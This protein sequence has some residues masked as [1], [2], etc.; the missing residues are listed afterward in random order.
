[1][2][3][4]FNSA[5]FACDECRH[6]FTSV[7][8]ARTHGF[9]SCCA[10]SLP[11]NQSVASSF[12]VVNTPASHFPFLNLSN[13]NNVVVETGAYFAVLFNVVL[14]LLNLSVN[15]QR[16]RRRR[17]GRMQMNSRHFIHKWF[18]VRSFSSRMGPVHWVV[19]TQCQRR[20]SRLQPTSLRNSTCSLVLFFV[21]CLNGHL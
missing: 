12:V 14:W 7:L 11:A 17:W 20:Q 18:C 4:G 15:R 9:K 6:R 2:L 1:M 5:M 13:D 19:W 8:L 16:W 3:S 21:F 10:L